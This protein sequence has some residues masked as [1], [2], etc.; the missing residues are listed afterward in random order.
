MAAKKGAAKKWYGATL[1]LKIARQRLAVLLVGSCQFATASVDEEAACAGSSAVSAVA[2]KEW[3]AVLCNFK[4]LAGNS[5]EVTNGCL[6]TF[7]RQWKQKR[8]DSEGRVPHV[9]NLHEPPYFYRLR[10]RTTSCLV[11]Q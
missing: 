11:Y 6:R 8:V 7:I 3:C 5:I 1:L 10:T 4:F 9:E 2:K